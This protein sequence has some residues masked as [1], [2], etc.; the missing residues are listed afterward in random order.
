M[1]LTSR[2]NLRVCV[3]VGWHS[4]NDLVLW[5][6]TGL[7]EMGAPVGVELDEIAP[8]SSRRIQG[9]VRSSEWR[10]FGEEMIV[11][12]HKVHPVYRSETM[13]NTSLKS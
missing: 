10:Y 1:P 2:R 13:H 4:D 6:A 11:I 12:C 5:H 9:G 7:P 8:I 3:S